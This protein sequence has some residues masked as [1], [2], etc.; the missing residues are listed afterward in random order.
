MIH[1]SVGWG[2]VWQVFAERQCMPSNLELR[3]HEEAASFERLQRYEGAHS[4]YIGSVEEIT[5]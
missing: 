5:W 4:I 1:D 3:G 2:R